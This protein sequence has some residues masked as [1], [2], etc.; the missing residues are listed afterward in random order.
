MQQFNANLTD[1]G[2]E[3]QA[4]GTANW[5]WSGTSTTGGLYLSPFS[6][7]GMA[8][9]Y[10]PTTTAGLTSYY[11]SSKVNFLPRDNRPASVSFQMYRY[12]V[13]S[14]DTSKRDALEVYINTTKSLNGAVLTRD[15]SPI[16]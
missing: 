10:N 1:C 15:N 3:P 13:G 2:W 7:P 5:V 4:P 6:A 14:K 16:R 9:F 8:K 12:R 11:Y